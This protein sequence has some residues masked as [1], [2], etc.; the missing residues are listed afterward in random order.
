MIM[1]AKYDH[2]VA[3]FPENRSIK[4]VTGVDNHTALWE[5]DKPAM[6]FSESFAKDIVFGLTLNGYVSAVITFLHG[7]ENIHN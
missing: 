2:Y 1:A 3:V 5:D 4:Y 6:K 7:V